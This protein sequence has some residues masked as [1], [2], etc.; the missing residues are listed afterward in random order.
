MR[1]F[2]F[3]LFIVVYSTHLYAQRTEID[4]LKEV[5]DNLEAMDTTY[6]NVVN[7]LAFRLSMSDQQSSI[8]YINRAITLAK[9]LKYEKGLVRAITIKGS[10]FLITGMPD[11]ALTYYLEALNYHP[12]RYPSEYV[13]LNNNIGEVYRRKEVYDSSIKYFNKALTQ[14]LEKSG[15][16]QPI[17]IYS[18]LGEVSLM[19]GNISQ[20]EGFFEKC[21]AKAIDINHLRGQ[22]YGYYGLAECA[23]LQG[24]IDKAVEL[25][26]KSTEVRLRGNHKRGII[27]SYLKLGDY[28]NS[29]PLNMPD[30]AFYY[31]HETKDLARTHEAND[32]L[33]EVYDKLY[34]YYFERDSVAKAATYLNLYK[35]LNDSIQNAAFISNV[36]KIKSALRSELI[37]AENELLKQESRQHQVEDKARL[38]LMLLSFLLVL[39]LIAFYYQYRKRQRVSDEAKS[40]ASFTH[41]LLSLSKELNTH[42]FNLDFFIKKLLIVSQETLR[43][44]RATYWIMDSE[45]QSISL[46]S[47]A[48]SKTSAKIPKIEFTK[49]EF[50]K[51]FSDFLTNRTVAVSRISQDGR[52]SEIYSKYF[53]KF[54]IES[55]LN[56]PIIVDGE[57]LGFISYTMTNHQ[58]RNWMVQEQRY[59]GSLADL[60][61]VAI[62]K[63]RT[64]SLENDK[65]ELI[66]KLKIRNKS[67]Q[68]FNAVISHNLR[69][70]LTQ[71]IGLT[72]LLQDQKAI[73]R[74]ESDEIISRISDSSNNVDSVIKELSVVLSESDPRQKDFRML[75]L[76]R[77][78][79]EIIDPLK[80]EKEFQNITIEQDLKLSRIRSYRPY[81]FEALSQ[82]I[83]NSIKFADSKRHLNIKIKS[84]EDA[85]KQYIVISDNGRG[86]DLKLFGDKIFKMYQRYHPEITGR[87]IG[88]FIVKNRINML[89]GFINVK[90]KE[91]E[92]TT[93]TIEFPKYNPDSIKV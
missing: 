8:S 5:L 72:S 92:G 73:S 27:Q 63:S 26:R 30:S 25:M 28:F 59:V 70:P 68:E 10:S 57:F 66:K 34:T 89:N 1:R 18:N 50:P 88:L 43:C 23:F 45:N 54:G 58:I 31:W 67:L 51:F 79:K 36:E 74:S 14:A 87:G 19:Q 20:A 38:I 37:D 47:K 17:I 75:S 13:S 46:K 86:M 55:I 64:N 29:H 76:E 65:V 52:L 78:L 77:L 35:H 93:F 83:A 4:S 60:I 41:T 48:E 90:S 15:N 21:L 42:S 3:L 91:G 9:E 82:L 2:L 33:S 85:H 62:R 32:L 39:G 80:K 6:L 12:E 69:E 49:D 7:D 16:T 24:N 81:L 40:E 44:D 53:K 56:A 11:Q 84:Y 61:V 71:I 22:G